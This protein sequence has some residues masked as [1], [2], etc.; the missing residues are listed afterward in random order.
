VTV[1]TIRFTVG[2]ECN[3]DSANRFGNGP[4]A[5]RLLHPLWPNRTDSFYDASTE[6]TTP[7]S[8]GLVL[9]HTLDPIP[10]VEGFLAPALLVS[11]GS[12]SSQIS[13]SGAQ[14]TSFNFSGVGFSPNGTF[15]RYSINSGG[16]QTELLPVLS[17]DSSGQH[18][19]WCLLPPFV[20]AN[21]AR[22]SQM[23]SLHIGARAAKED[24]VTRRGAY[25]GKSKAN[26]GLAQ[27][28][29][30]LFHP[31]GRSAGS[32]PAL[33]PVGD[34]R[35][36]RHSPSPA[37][38]LAAYR[39]ARLRHPDRSIRLDVP[40]HPAGKLAS[41]ARRRSRLPGRISA[42]L[43]GRAGLSRRVPVAADGLRRCRVPVESRRLCGPLLARK[44][45][46]GKDAGIGGAFSPLLTIHLLPMTG[47]NESVLQRQERLKRKR[48]KSSECR[49]NTGVLS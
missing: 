39:L 46:S 24:A 36:S 22:A 45:S 6:V 11:G 3:R 38:A 28:H 37:A 10:F 18:K 27:R 32:A 26:R 7:D 13:C 40:A 12:C 16:N 44:T 21:E 4:C 41:G 19:G 42:A 17:A 15:H 30:F 14:G 48:M 8:D 29:E 31:R 5:V 33:H 25:M 43:P 47:R 34:I 20:F 9:A 49:Y 35:S 1:K 23:K 2:N